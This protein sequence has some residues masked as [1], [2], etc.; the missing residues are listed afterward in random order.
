MRQATHV[1]ACVTGVLAHMTGVTCLLPG[2]ACQ[3]ALICTSRYP[4]PAPKSTSGILP[5][6]STA[7]FCTAG[8]LVC[9]LPAASHHFIVGVEL[10]EVFTTDMEST[11]V[12]VVKWGFLGE[13]WPFFRPNFVNMEEYRTERN[14]DEVH[15][16]HVNDCPQC[17]CT[18]SV[19]CCTDPP[20]PS[21]Y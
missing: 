5:L 16:Q 14:V 12:H 7:S 8:S 18:V 6:A 20:A 3:W 9:W 13:S 11:P 4:T 15:M 2:I 19:L 17:S 1:L 10:D 21:T